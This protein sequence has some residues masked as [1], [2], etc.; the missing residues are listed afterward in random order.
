MNDCQALSAAQL[1]R[2][3]WRQVSTGFVDMRLGA[4]FAAIFMESKD[5]FSMVVMAFGLVGA[6]C[7]WLDAA[8]N[9]RAARR[10]SAAASNDREV[11]A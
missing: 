8:H 4:L 2:E 7:E 9:F 1:S 5:W 3:A 11:I 10:H 6:T